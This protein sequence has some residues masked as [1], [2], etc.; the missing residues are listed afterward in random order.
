MNKAKKSAYYFIL[1]C[2]I[3]SLFS[4]LAH[5]GARSILGPYL[6]LL[7]TSAAVIAFV[8]GLGECIGYGLRIVSGII[9]DKTKK[10]WTA[11]IIDYAL[12][13]GEKYNDYF[14]RYVH[15]RLLPS[16]ARHTTS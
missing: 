2:G 16:V 9:C 1:L 14:K 11:A 13:T 12:T 3:I 8:S 10:Y 5:E 6:G 4:D 15:Q 7:G